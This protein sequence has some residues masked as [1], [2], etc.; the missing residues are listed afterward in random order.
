MPTDTPTLMPTNTPTATPI[1]STSTP[2]PSPT[3]PPTLTPAPADAVVTAAQLNMRSGPG[4]AFGTIAALTK[5]DALDVI[6]QSENCAW[7]QVRTTGGI[8]GW[9]AHLVGSTEYTTLNIAC[10]SVAKVV[11]PTPSPRSQPA[12]PPAAA[13]LPVKQAILSPDDYADILP[14]TLCVMNAFKEDETFSGYLCFVATKPIGA[15]EV[16]MLIYTL[17]SCRSG[18]PC[19]PK[20][21]DGEKLPLPTTSSL[22]SDASLVGI[23]DGGF[24]LTASANGY[25]LL[26]SVSKGDRQLASQKLAAV[27]ARQF[28]AIR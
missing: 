7:L 4:T 27:A 2:T 25:A 5:G 20:S 3:S 22:P 6:G 21:P 26:I 17:T 1:P 24:T 15:N 8:E 12:G 9:V 13:R 23:A 14:T 28:A 10:D 16:T 18:E 11:V 19:A